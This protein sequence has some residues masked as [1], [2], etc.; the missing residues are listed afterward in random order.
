MTIAIGGLLLIGI[1]VFTQKDGPAK[2][3]AQEPEIEIAV[4]AQVESSNPTS[5]QLP[6]PDA[7]EG[8]KIVGGILGTAGAIGL[9]YSLSLSTTVGT[10]GPYAASSEVMNLDLMFQKGVAIASSLAALVTG[11]FCIAIGSIIKAIGQNGRGE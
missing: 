7:G 10:S 2:P 4:P 11:V 1:F 5:V 3:I 6:A 8:W 9:V